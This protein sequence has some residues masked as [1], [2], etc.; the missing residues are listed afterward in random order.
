[1]KH[2]KILL[3]FTIFFI[4]NVKAYYEAPVDI[5]KMDVYEIQEAIDDGYLTY[6]LLIR[7]YLDRIEAYDK[8]YKA[9]KDFE[10]DDQIEI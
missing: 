1:M 9:I 10:E 2:I 8:N 3:V 6:E 4:V 7:L 5:T